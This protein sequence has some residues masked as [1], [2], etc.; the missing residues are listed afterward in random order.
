MTTAKFKKFVSYWLSLVY[1]FALTLP[2][3][4]PLLT[5]SAVATESTTP[6]QFEFNAAEFEQ[7]L[8]RGMQ[9]WQVP[10]LAVAVV[11]KD[12]ELFSQTLGTTKLNAQGKPTGASVDEHTV[13]PLSSTSKG[14]IA[15]AALVLA[16]QGKLSLD[17]KVA[18]YIPELKLQAPFA[19]QEM[20]VRDVLSQRVGLDNLGHYWLFVVGWNDEKVLSKMP[21]V[22]FVHSFRSEFSYSN[23]LYHFMGLLVTRASGQPWQTFIQN[24]VWQPLGMHSTYVSQQQIPADKTRLHGHYWTGKNAKFS[25]KIDDYNLQIATPTGSFW[26]TLHD[27]KRYLQFFL[28]SG[29]TI[30]DY[31]VNREREHFAHMQKMLENRVSNTKPS[32]PLADYAGTYRDE[33]GALFYLVI[34]GVIINVINLTCTNSIF[35]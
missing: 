29:K 13:V 19:S 24:E 35:A 34:H 11:T 30:H 25:D 1:S 32:L 31:Y 12:S 17:D 10:G 9:Q 20:T 28:N 4:L 16:E 22:D 23:T 6:T 15:L 8:E 26:T 33:Y 2:I 21:L 7:Q 3:T 14:M 18:K 27:T 5:V